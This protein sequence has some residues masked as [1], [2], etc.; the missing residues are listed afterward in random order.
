MAPVANERD[1]MTRIQFSTDEMLGSLA[2]WLRLMGYDTNYERDR[3]DTEILEKAEID[4]R[5]LLTR[6]KKLAERAGEHGLYVS[7]RDLD[8]QLRQ[9]TRAYGLIFDE[10]RSR[11][12]ACNGELT[13]ISKEE[14]SK[15]VP[16]GALRSNEQFFLCGSC[17]KYYWKGSHWHNIRRMMATL[18]ESDHES[19]R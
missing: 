17:G 16:E 4:G 8:E 18:N 10:D 19:S 3:G 13:L 14:A 9:V 1:E 2:R 7:A 15:G 5:I 6:D 11:C 12:T